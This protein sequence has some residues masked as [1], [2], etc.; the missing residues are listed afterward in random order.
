MAEDPGATHPIHIPQRLQPLPPHLYTF[1]HRAFLVAITE[2]GA[3]HPADPGGPAEAAEVAA[4]RRH[5]RLPAAF[6]G[7]HPHRRQASTLP[8]SSRTS[9]LRSGAWPIIKNA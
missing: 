7:F 4:A 2:A 6:R 8:T 3:D 9:S 1:P 5:P